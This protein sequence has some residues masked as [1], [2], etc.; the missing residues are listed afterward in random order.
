VRVKKHLCVQRS[1]KP[2]TWRRLDRCV[3]CLKNALRLSRFDL[4][5]ATLQSAQQRP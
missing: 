3:D 1:D 2:R 4:P 5:D